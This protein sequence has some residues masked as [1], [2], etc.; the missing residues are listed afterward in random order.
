M[1]SSY[2]GMDE[3]LLQSA[4]REFILLVY[5]VRVQLD[6]GHETLNMPIFSGQNTG[7]V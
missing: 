4:L 2:Y 7:V 1:H 6:L 5:V 3:R